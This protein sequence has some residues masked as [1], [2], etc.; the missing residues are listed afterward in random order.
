MEKRGPYRKYQINT[1]MEI[2]E[3]TRRYR[4][5]KMQKNSVLLQVK[6][7]CIKI[8]AVEGR[9]GLREV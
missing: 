3:S 4:K 5:R 9:A 2:P 1:E 6:L 8:M 7:I